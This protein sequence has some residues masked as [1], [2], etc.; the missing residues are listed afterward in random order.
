MWHAV[1]TVN[2]KDTWDRVPELEALRLAQALPPHLPRKSLLNRP[3][4]RPIGHRHAGPVAQREGGP[5]MPKRD[6]T[7]DG[8]MVPPGLVD[9]YLK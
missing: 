8:F 1:Y 7:V 3:P 4:F 6:E 5:A 2:G 9:Q